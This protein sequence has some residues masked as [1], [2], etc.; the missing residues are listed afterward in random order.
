MRQEAVRPAS[1]TSRSLI[2]YFLLPSLP[3]FM[4]VLDEWDVLLIGILPRVT[5]DRKWQGLVE[6]KRT[7]HTA[8]CFTRTDHSMLVG[9]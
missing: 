8:R 7:N 1:F 2:R 3:T 5:Y 6:T 4:S 9:I